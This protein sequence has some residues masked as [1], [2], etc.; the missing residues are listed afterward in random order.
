MTESTE[1]KGKL[2]LTDDEIET[3]PTLGRRSFLLAAVG[4]P[5][6]LAACV[7]A[8]PVSTG[9]GTGWTDTDNGSTTDAAGYGRGPHRTNYSGMTD[10]DTG[11]FVD[12]P[13]Y[14]R[15]R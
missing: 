15:G 10:A 8:G 2:T 6:A 3:R 11:G 7:P 5:A 1:D 9:G 4:A 12:S 13:G 14:G